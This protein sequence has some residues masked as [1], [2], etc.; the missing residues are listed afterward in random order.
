LLLLLLLASIEVLLHLI[1]V[2]HQIPQM[3]RPQ[4]A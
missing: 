2:L 4:N 1:L 3:P